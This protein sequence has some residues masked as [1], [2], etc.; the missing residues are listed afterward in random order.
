MKTSIVEKK[1]IDF[2]SFNFFV[3]I[4]SRPDTEKKGIY[5]GVEERGRRLTRTEMLESIALRPC[6]SRSTLGTRVFF[7][8]VRRGASFYRSKAEDTSGEVFRAG[9]FLRLDRNRKPRM[10]SLWHLPFSSER[11]IWPFH[12]V[13]VQGWQRNEQ[14]SVMH[15]QSCCFAH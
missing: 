5:V 12:V 10:N 3:I 4:P 15:V 9:H 11:K 7:S 2:S 1:L 6:R 8:R 13:F 14:K